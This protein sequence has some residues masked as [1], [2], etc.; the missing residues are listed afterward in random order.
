MNINSLSDKEKNILLQLSYI[1]LP[2]DLPVNT[3]IKELATIIKEE[4]GESN[5]RVNNFYDFVEQNTDNNIN[6]LV[7]TGYKNCNYGEGNNVNDESKSGFVG[8]AFVDKETNE[9][10]TLFR[11]SEFNG[12]GNFYADWGVDGNL[13]ATLGIEITQ[14]KQALEFFKAYMS[15]V[16]YKLILGHSKGGNLTTHVITEMIDDKN[17]IVEVLNAQPIYWL[18]LTE[19]QKELLKSDRYNYVVTV[20]D[21]VSYLGLPKGIVDKFVKMDGFSLNP[22]APHFE[23]KVSITNNSYDE[24]NPL[25]ASWFQDTSFS[26]VCNFVVN[27]T[28]GRIKITEMI[29]KSAYKIVT[30]V[31]NGTIK[32]AEYIKNTCSEAINKISQGA[33]DLVDSVKNYFNNLMDNILT[34]VKSKNIASIKGEISTIIV[35]DTNRVA[36]YESQLRQIRIRISDI[37]NRIDKL[38]FK[39]GLLG[40]DNI[41]RADILTTG[42]SKMNSVIIALQRTRSILEENERKLKVKAQQI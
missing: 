32:I 2:K 22:F 10:I 15:D 33:K 34:K 21:V 24:V 40:M 13:G 28:N 11:G 41:F 38:Y 5:L 16:E 30:N 42:K 4:Y 29:I 36:N 14:Q 12:L 1:D 3:T 9:G 20:G 7:L 39:V 26:G 35:A 18:G 25:L 23:H 6:N 27:I 19:E 17:I 8:Y 37:N 31:L